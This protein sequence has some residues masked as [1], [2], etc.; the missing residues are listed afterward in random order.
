MSDKIYYYTFLYLYLRL[1]LRLRTMLHTIYSS[2]FEQTITHQHVPLR[3]SHVFLR[4]G[5]QSHV[6][7]RNIS[8]VFAC[9]I[10]TSHIIN[11]GCVD[12]FQ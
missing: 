1:Y 3:Q 8:I 2:K 5:S 10:Y 12:Y 4:W 11:F 7:L 6:F 9:F